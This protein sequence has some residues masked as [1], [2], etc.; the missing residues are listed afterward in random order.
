MKTS[1]KAVEMIATFEGFISKPYLDLVGIPTIGHGFTFYPKTKKRVLL[2]DP[3]ITVE[4]SLLIL[5]DMLLQ[6][7]NGVKLAV[8]K[9]INQNQFD[10]LVS[11]S[12]NV[13][14]SA[15]KNST[16]LKKLNVNPNDKSIRNEFLRWNKAGGRVFQGLTN[17]RQKEADLYFS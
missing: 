14:I 9:P 11:F 4:E 16:L 2:T 10:A 8:Q 17:R 12:Y 13:G 5:A 3:P 6:F 1:P 7:E 15:F